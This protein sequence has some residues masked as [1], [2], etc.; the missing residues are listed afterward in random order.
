MLDVVRGGWL[1]DGCCRNSHRTMNMNEFLQQNILINFPFK[2]EK[3]Y[4]KNI[5]I[6][7]QNVYE[8]RFYSSVFFLFSY[9][10][11]TITN[12]T[13]RWNIRR[14]NIMYSMKI[15]IWEPRHIKIYEGS[16]LRFRFLINFPFPLVMFWDGYLYVNGFAF[17]GGP[18][19]WLWI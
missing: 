17:P 16:L 13:T 11:E 9:F 14:T 15:V 8:F 19:D 12:P 18:K 10:L 2:I 3:I 4:N 1:L 7:W 5:K 6:L